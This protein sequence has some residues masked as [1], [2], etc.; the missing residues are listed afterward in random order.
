[1]FIGV[2]LDLNDRE[3]DRNHDGSS[4]DGPLSR[5]LLLRL[6][7]LLLVSGA[8]IGWIHAQS[9]A[10]LV[11]EDCRLATPGTALRA[12]A[13]CARYPVAENP[14]EPDG[15]QIQ[16]KLAVIPAQGKPVQPDAVVFLAGGPGQSATESW[17][18]IT[19]AF[20]AV[21]R[22]RDILLVDQRGT[23]ESNRLA[24]PWSEELE[25]VDPETLD[26]AELTR[27]CL[28]QLDGDARFY[29]T[30]LAVHDLEAVRQALGYE[31][32]TLV[33][34]SYGTR[35]ALEYLRHYPESVRAVV[36]DGVVP[37]ELVL[38]SEHARNA[39]QALEDAFARCVADSACQERF[40]NP[41]ESFAALRQALADGSMKIAMRHPATGAALEVPFTALS[42][43]AAIRLLNYQ[44]EGVA[45]IPLLLDDAVT[46]Q[47]FSR[48]AA[49]ALM[50][51]AALARSLS[52]GMELSVVCSEDEPFFTTRESD[53]DTYLG[54]RFTAMIE[55][56]CGVWP[57]GEIPEGFHTPV[58]S[59]KPVLL[60]SGENDPVTP[61]RY[62]EQV[63]TT[64]SNS[65]HVVAPGQGH[66]VIPRGCVPR[67][68]AAFIETPD[69]NTLDVACVDDL[70]PAA[71]FTTFAGPE[72]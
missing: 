32:L 58:R 27:E 64:L 26:L 50:T 68:L 70:G 14:A 15:K 42:L 5:A 9:H 6:L 18:S 24:C 2:K 41:G 33:G 13:R 21:R 63:A 65:R 45:L 55:E 72:P 39:Q 62:G 71:F 3:H 7:L 30:T 61:P 25:L 1:L 8:P 52:R 22:E 51:S 12:H 66:N 4:T 46:T 38:G 28:E 59:D 43:A 60:L 34:V 36:L 44:T 31:Q 19:G 23:G 17:P 40:G 35:V 48:V 47:D 67:V 11:F 54:Q 10:P 57:R 49:Q 37:P 16:L 56:Q 53:N 69:V 29:T 20:R